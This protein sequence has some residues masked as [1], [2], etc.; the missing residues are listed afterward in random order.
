MR[1]QSLTL[2]QKMILI[3]VFE[4]CRNDVVAWISH[5][6][7]AEDCGRSRLTI[8]RAMKGLMGSWLIV[9]R[10]QLEGKTNMYRPSARLMSY[11]CSQQSR[12]AR[13]IPKG[14]G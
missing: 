1:I 6:R 5:K 14:G 9:Q 4:I 10:R 13:R 12:A 7:L 3:R 8:I 11:L 2:I